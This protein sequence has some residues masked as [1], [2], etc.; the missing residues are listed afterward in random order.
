MIKGD[1]APDFSLT[2]QNGKQVDLTDFSGKKVVLADQFDL[3]APKTALITFLT[4]QKVEKISDHILQ[5]G[6]VRLELSGI[7]LQRTYTQ[8]KR[9]YWGG[10]LTAVVLKST[11][12][13]YKITFREK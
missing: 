8:E 3:A 12:N 7:E 6:E 4:P 13:H 9:L 2:D 1:K 5:I 10:S 11:G